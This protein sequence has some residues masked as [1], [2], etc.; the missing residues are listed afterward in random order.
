MAEVEVV[1]PVLVCGRGTV[2]LPEES[3]RDTVQLRGCGLW[4]FVAPENTLMIVPRFSTAAHHE[5]GID[6]GLHV[7]H[8]L[9]VRI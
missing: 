1:S 5:K 8:C 6:I 3:T 7:T 9:G 2:K 4:R